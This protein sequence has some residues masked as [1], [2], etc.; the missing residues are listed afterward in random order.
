L[1]VLGSRCP[2]APEPLSAGG[3]VNDVAATIQP[4]ARTNRNEFRDGSLAGRLY[5]RCG[6]ND[7][8]KASSNL[9]SNA[10]KFTEDGKVALAVDREISDGEN[11]VCFSVSD[12]GPGIAPE[13]MNKLFKPFT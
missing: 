6:S 12:T 3:L 10:C 13:D 7:S 5:Y 8:G 4:V 2:A 11:W 1:V 9:R